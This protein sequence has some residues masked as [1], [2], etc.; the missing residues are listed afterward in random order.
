MG[1]MNGG[2]TA[3]STKL[4]QVYKLIEQITTFKQALLHR[5]PEGLVPGSC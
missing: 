1:I 4:T 5:V 3:A 2:T